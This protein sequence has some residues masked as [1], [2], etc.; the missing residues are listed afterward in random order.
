CPRSQ[1]RLRR[2]RKLASPASTSSL[3][4][5]TKRVDGRDKPGPDAWRKAAETSFLGPDRLAQHALDFGGDVADALEDPLPLPPRHQLGLLAGDL[6]VV[7]DEILVLLDCVKRLAQRQR[8]LHWR[9]LGQEDTALHLGADV[10][11]QEQRLVF[12]ARG[13][14]A[15]G[16]QVEIVERDHSLL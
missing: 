13:L 12:R 9:S 5:Q 6:A 4:Y 14:L 11:H 8:R 16:L 2:L 1:P 3:P 15:E 10:I 7:F